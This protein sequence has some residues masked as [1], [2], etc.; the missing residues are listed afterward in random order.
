MSK[1]TALVLFAVYLAL[2]LHAQV[3]ERRPP[4]IDEHMHAPARPGP[5][6]NFLKDLDALI[7]RWDSLE[8]R[9]GVLMDVPD[10]VSSWH[11][12]V[13]DRVI[14]GLQLPCENGISF[15]EAILCKNAARFLRLGEEISAHEEG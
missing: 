8:V 6:E 15:K 12:R 4:V 7:T 9:L 2:P 3:P 11:E 14:P 5:V 13:R 1:A 10:V